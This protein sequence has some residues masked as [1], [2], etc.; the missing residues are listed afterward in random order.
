MTQ[1][2][3]LDFLGKQNAPKVGWLVLASGMAVMGWQMV[4][5]SELLQ[6]NAALKSE[7]QKIQASQKI[8]R[9]DVKSQ[10]VP[11]AAER[12][13]ISQARA[14]AAQLN[15][16]WES[17][18]SLVE[19]AQHPDVALLALDPK[20]RNGQIRLTAEAK[21]ASTMVA[22]VTSLQ[23]NKLLQNAVL[24]SHQVQVQ[25]PGTPFRFQVLAQ[26][27]ET[28]A[29]PLVGSALDVTQASVPAEKAAR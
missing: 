10:P 15:D 9:Q 17:L 14:V 20:G 22:Y 29:V 18:L 28:R 2:I 16:P 27:K 24:T 1:A 26:W 25:Q 23:Q 5:Y 12:S 4:A 7:L 6:S 13:A 21:D 11:T 8:S 3:H 19:T